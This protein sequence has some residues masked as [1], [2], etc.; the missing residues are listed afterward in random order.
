MQL[1]PLDIE[2]IHVPYPSQSSYY[3]VKGADQAKRWLQEPPIPA[4]IVI[5]TMEKIKLSFQKKEIEEL[6][7]SSLEIYGYPQTIHTNLEFKDIGELDYTSK[8]LLVKCFKEIA[9]LI[10]DCRRTCIYPRN[11]NV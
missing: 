8:K 6:N 9:N 11:R 1:Q 7:D 3:T 4:S 10:H 2:S 5:T